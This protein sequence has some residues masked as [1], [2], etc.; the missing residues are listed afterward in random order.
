LIGDCVEIDHRGLNTNMVE[1]LGQ[2]CLHAAAASDGTVPQWLFTENDTNS[3][4]HFGIPNVSPYTKDAFHRYVIA[5]EFEAINPA[6]TGTKA[7]AHYQLKIPARGH[8]TLQLRLAEAA[9]SQTA[10]GL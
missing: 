8:V 3:Q 2:Y 5:G 7:A 6:Q 4:R 10:S 9:A 1:D